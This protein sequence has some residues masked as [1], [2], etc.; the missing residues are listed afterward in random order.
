MVEHN[1]AFEADVKYRRIHTKYPLCR[2]KNV[3]AS[4]T[5]SKPKAILIHI[6]AKIF[7]G[8]QTNV[9]LADSCRKIRTC[10]GNFN[11]SLKI[12]DQVEC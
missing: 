8:Y 9:S 4:A 6:R 3:N 10:S 5:E 12:R 11:F 7:V 2:L 1:H